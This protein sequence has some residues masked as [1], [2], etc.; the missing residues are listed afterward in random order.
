M[1]ARQ[2]CPDEAAMEQLFLAEQEGQEGQE[3]PPAP[4]TVATP[5]SAA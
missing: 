3:E 5:S 4:E 2:K 1:M